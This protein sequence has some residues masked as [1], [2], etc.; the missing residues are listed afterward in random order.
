MFGFCPRRHLLDN[1]RFWD[2]RAYDATITPIQAL[3]PYCTSPKRYIPHVPRPLDQECS[4]PIANC[5][6]QELALSEV[7]GVEHPR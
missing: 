3:R 4:H 1:L 2:S 5:K 6:R 7:E